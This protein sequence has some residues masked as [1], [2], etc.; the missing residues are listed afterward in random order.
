MHFRDL[1]SIVLLGAFAIKFWGCGHNG[2]TAKGENQPSARDGG[3]G[4]IDPGFSIDDPLFNQSTTTVA[5]WITP[6]WY[7]CE[8]EQS[9]CGLPCPLNDLWVAINPK[10][11]RGSAVCS[12]CMSVDG[13][14]GTVVV[15]VIENCGG[16]CDAGEIE[17]SRV[18]APRTL[19]SRGPHFVFL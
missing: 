8:T 5:E 16:A 15:E 4:A 1:L 2:E 9:A 17:L 14:K 13:P 10:D 6:E 19:R 12:S 11:F 7:T 18:V 3:L